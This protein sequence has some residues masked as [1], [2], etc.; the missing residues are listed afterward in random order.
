MNYDGKGITDITDQV[1]AFRKSLVASADAEIV[2]VT[3][4]VG[5]L[6]NNIY[7][8]NAA[9]TYRNLY[10]GNEYNNENFVSCDLV[11]SYAWDTALMFI[12]KCSGQENYATTEYE[13]TINNTGDSTDVVC[14][15]FDMGGNLSEWT[16]ETNVYNE[17]S[18]NF[19]WGYTDVIRRI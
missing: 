6:W 13:W 7:Q 5:M 9:F 8:V 3:S 11:N 15:I 4:T 2:T 17:I 14:N 12:Q 10:A 18:G 19:Y 1:P 16:T